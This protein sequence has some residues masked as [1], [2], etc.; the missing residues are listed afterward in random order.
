MPK[1]Q[2][3]DIID[4]KVPEVSIFPGLVLLVFG[5]ENL[6][7]NPPPEIAVLY[8]VVKPDTQE[9]GPK[10]HQPNPAPRLIVPLK[11]FQA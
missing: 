8:S 6:V 11:K 7:S 2:K 5:L 1:N 3:S 4:K 10:Q 9:T